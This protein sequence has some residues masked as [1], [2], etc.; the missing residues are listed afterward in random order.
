MF[1]FN[2]DDRIQFATREKYILLIILPK[3]YT[4]WYTQPKPRHVRKQ[5]AN[6]MRAVDVFKIAVT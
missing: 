1:V 6:A 2:T 3:A 5:S 4:R